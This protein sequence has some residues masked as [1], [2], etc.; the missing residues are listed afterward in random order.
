MLE[1]VQ[2]SGGLFAAVFILAFSG[3]VRGAVNLEWRPAAQTVRAGDVVR[4][5]LFARSSSAAPQPFRALSAIVTWDPTRLELLG[6]DDAPNGYPW[7]ISFFPN[8]AGLDR[9]NDDCGDGVFCST[10]T[11]RPFNDG[12]AYYEAFARFAPA[13]LPE[14]TTGGLRITTFRFRVLRPGPAQ[15]AFAPVGD[16]AAKTRVVG[17]AAPGTDVTG[18]LGAP[19]TLDVTAVTATDIPLFLA[20]LS[21]PG[22]SVSPNCRRFDADGDTD[23]DAKDAAAFQDAYVRP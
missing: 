14:A 23:V 17:A 10:Y 4:L 6:L 7:L 11:G 21:G 18:L 22:V 15:V 8:D 20:C 12:D 13:P 19:A 3:G 2:P 5:D 16:G 1:R 9:F